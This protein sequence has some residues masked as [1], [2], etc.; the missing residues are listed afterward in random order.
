MV[1]LMDVGG[2]NLF[3]IEEEYV[4]LR[5]ELDVLVG[6]IVIVERLIFDRVGKMCDE[7]MKDIK[8]FE[9]E[10]RGDVFVGGDEVVGKVKGDI[11]NEMMGMVEYIV[12]G[13][14][15]VDMMKIVELRDGRKMVEW[16][17]FEKFI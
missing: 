3:L 4:I 10:D 6:E 1:N 15:Y 8:G 5:I 16:E 17:E 13:R 9:V 11:I 7:L 14:D 12:G 2:V